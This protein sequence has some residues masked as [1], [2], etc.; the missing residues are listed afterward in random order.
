MPTEPQL[1]DL[2]GASRNSVRIVTA[3]GSHEPEAA[4]DPVPRSST[5]SGFI[6][7]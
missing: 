3:V 2:L 6:R 5:G 7:R 4:P 1:M